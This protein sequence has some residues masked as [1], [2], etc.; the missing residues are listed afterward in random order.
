MFGLWP[1]SGWGGFVIAAGLGR[2]WV[3]EVLRQDAAQ[4][5]DGC[6]LGQSAR[7][8]IVVGRSALGHHHHLIDRQAALRERLEGDRQVGLTI[9]DHHDLL[10]PFGRQPC[11]PRQPL[12]RRLDAR[13]FP[14]PAVDG[15][16]GQ[17][18]ELGMQ[19]VEVSTDGS[20]PGFQRHLK[21]NLEHLH[22]LIVHMFDPQC[23]TSGCN[24]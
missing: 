18:H 12:L 24:P 21:R 16:P 10:G 8:T 19:H 11:L 5:R 7:F 14:E 17:G 23:N 4:L 20:E 1:S 6:G 15:R 9:G 22:V 3:E 13:T 2:G